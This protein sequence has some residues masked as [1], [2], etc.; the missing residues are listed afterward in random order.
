M[1][2]GRRGGSE[3]QGMA[4]PRMRIGWMR[5]EGRRD[6]CCA[7]VADVNRLKVTK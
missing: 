2:R 5:E 4:G 1:E 6:Y 3:N 7:L